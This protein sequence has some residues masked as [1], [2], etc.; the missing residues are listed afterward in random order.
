MGLEHTTST[1]RDKRGT[2]IVY[3]ADSQLTNSAIKQILHFK[4]ITYGYFL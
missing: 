3:V 4:P 2:H 1:L